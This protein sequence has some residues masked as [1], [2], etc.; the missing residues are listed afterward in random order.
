M[1][2]QICDPRREQET[3]PS[4]QERIAQL[5][6]RRTVVRQLI[7]LL[8]DYTDCVVQESDF[9]RPR[10]DQSGSNRV[11]TPSGPGRSDLI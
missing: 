7:E 6:R 11:K 4:L 2:K 9:T 3:N 10:P 1:H 5:H 8:T